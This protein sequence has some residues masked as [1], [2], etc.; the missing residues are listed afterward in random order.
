M[1]TFGYLS[2]RMGRKFGMV[3]FTYVLLASFRVRR[4]IRPFT[5]LCFANFLDARYR[6]C[7]VVL[8]ALRCVIWC[9]PQR[10]WLDRYAERVS[11]S[12]VLPDEMDEQIDQTHHTLH[13]WVLFSFLLGIGVG[14][15]Y[16]CGSVAASEQSEEPGV[17]KNAQHRWFALATSA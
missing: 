4:Q 12:S 7:R 8:G 1:L 3:S 14:A 2:D 6:H 9:A 5:T 13:A 17:S 15:E 11:V 16:P 10:W